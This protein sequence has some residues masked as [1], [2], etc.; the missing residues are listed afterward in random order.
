MTTPDFNK[1]LQQMLDAA[2]A[3]LGGRLPQTLSY[4][5]AEL[6]QLLEETKKVEMRKKL[7]Q[8]DAA[9]AEIQLNSLLN[10]A[11]TVAVTGE[12]IVKVEAEKAI[13]AA[14]KALTDALGVVV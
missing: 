9:T 1:I 8:I 4:V 5:E 2:K 10:A 3:S 14:I 7:G 13:N 6:K 11:G 12:G